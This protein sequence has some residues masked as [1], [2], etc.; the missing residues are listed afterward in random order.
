[1]NL[2]LPFP[3]RSREYALGAAS[4]QRPARSARPTGDRLALCWAATACPHALACGDAPDLVAE[5]F[6]EPEVAIRPGRGARRSALGRGGAGRG[7][8]AAWRDAPG[9]RDVE[10]R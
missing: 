5:G 4:I 3:K 10:C 2:I 7:E 6:G 8:A 9:P 1:M